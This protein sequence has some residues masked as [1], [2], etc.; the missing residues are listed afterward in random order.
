MFKNYI[1][2]A[3][4]NLL[5][6]KGYSAINIL[7]LTVSLTVCI[8]IFIWVQDELKMDQFHKDG[9]RI[10]RVL[11]NVRTGDNGIRTWENA[12][13]PLIE[14][15]QENYP[16][17]ET[18]GAIDP[19]NRMQFELGGKTFLEDG[20]YATNEVF[21]VL[22]IPLVEGIKTKIFE[23]P[24][25][26]LISEKLA[27]KLFGESW[28]GQIIGEPLKINGKNDYMVSGVF[29]D[30]PVHSSMQ[31]DFVM[32]LE[33]QR[34]NNENPF[35]WGDYNSRTFLKLKKGASLSAIQAKMK[36]IIK[37]NNPYDE[38]TVL[39]LQPMERMYLH[40]RFI[41]G[42]EN[43][44]RIEYVQL[45]GLAAIF[46]LLIACINFM[47]LATARASR[48]AKEVGVR[49]T[50]GA[51][52]QALIAQFMVEAGLITLF[53][54]GLAVFMGKVLTPYFQQIT[55]KFLTLD[56]SQPAFWGSMILVVLLTTLLAGS[57]PAFFLS[58]IRISNVLKGQL[59]K[60]LSGNSL[61]RA[62]VVAQF[63]LSAI[64]V[65]GALVVQKQVHFIKNK[66]LGMDK[67][68]VLYFRIPPGAEE[69]RGT[70]E[71]ELARIPGIEAT[72]F[73]NGIPISV[74]SQ[75]GDP[76]WEGMTE[77]QDALFY[78][79]ISDH[80]FLSMMNI[81][82]LKGRDFSSEISTDTVNFL[83]NE[84]AAKA[85]QLDDPIGKSLSFWGRTGIIIGIV[86]NF[87]IGS[88]HETIGPLIISNIPTQT[89]LALLR[90]DPE[91]VEE[92][93]SGT[94][95]VFNRFSEGF[96][97]RY[98]FLDDRYLQMYQSEQRIGQLSN[99]FALIA[100][101][102]SCL[103][104]FGLSTFVA[105]QKT[106]EIGI[107]KVLGASVTHIFTMLSKDFLLL[108]A[109]ALVIALPIG[110]YLIQSW[111]SGFAYQTPVSWTVFL[112][113]GGIAVLVA[114]LTVSLQ[115]LRAA[116]TNPV[117]ALRSE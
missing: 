68:N 42:R 67:E 30:L 73:T 39:F 8:L 52:R 109:I 46:L 40:N 114:L 106:K 76:M 115:S 11:S 55:G 43:G 116:L 15:M 53:S 34:K 83:V 75:T 94:Q 16:E 1:K 61:R 13:Y 60:K 107:R 78:V 71:N 26:I 81:E 82:L 4:R 70:F 36:D 92:V 35:P 62:L 10:Y 2:I 48:R 23:E 86:K 65:V 72:T 22:T 57:Y 17:V 29:A 80:R 41:A 58:S 69:S 33:E 24:G 108:V 85:M 102:V 104:L 100:L 9:D 21:D 79:L 38:G 63:V 44:G 28:K 90:V 89:S 18:I 32:D 105:E 56:L 98:D 47:N 19:T 111:L 54:V 84:T 27:E 25:S 103:G 97:F 50:I 93:I 12:P 77:D 51:D 3:F 91:R 64:L 88:L 59:S 45:F 7:G 49:K 87:H 96:P 117:K 20:I 110:W 6:Q 66:H 31:F 95:T 112:L 113:A 5:R 99:W 37:K 74:D 101:F 14:Y